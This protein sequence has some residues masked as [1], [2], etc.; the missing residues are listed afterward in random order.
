MLG[1]TLIPSL[2][3]LV[4]MYFMPQTTRWLVSRGRND[5]AREVLRRSRSEEEMENEIREKKE[6]EREEEGG[7]R[8]LMAPWVR[9]ALVVAISFA[10]FQQ[11]IRHK[12]HHLLHTHHPHQRRLRERSGHLRQPQH[13]SRKC[14]YDPRG[15]TTY[16]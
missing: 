4:E 11:I 13:R 16:R 1:L 8:E 6:V 2:V 7:L 15:H 5:D 14:P 3:L 12:H 9:P 10:Y